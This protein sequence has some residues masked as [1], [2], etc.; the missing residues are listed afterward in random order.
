MALQIEGNMPYYLLCDCQRNTKN[1][2]AKFHENIC[3]LSPEIEKKTKNVPALPSPPP[4]KKPRNSPKQRAI[5]PNKDFSPT[6][7]RVLSR[8]YVKN[9]IRNQMVF[10]K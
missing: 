2:F 5:P 9:I 3:N 1:I 4:K 6:A 7:I 8:I 10:K